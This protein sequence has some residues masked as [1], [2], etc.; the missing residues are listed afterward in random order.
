MCVK[1]AP[2][3]EI[4]ASEQPQMQPTLGRR[5]GEGE[6][7]ESAYRSHILLPI[8][9][10]STCLEWLHSAPWNHPTP[11][12]PMFEKESDGG[13]DRLLVPCSSVY[14]VC[15]AITVVRIEAIGFPTSSPILGYQRA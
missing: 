9:L 15:V 6:S 5:E 8:S 10:L 2:W 7:R 3:K 12:D 13:E 11:T 14:C 1:G 4:R